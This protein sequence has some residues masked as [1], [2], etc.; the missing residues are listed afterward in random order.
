MNT[1]TTKSIH[2]RLGKWLFNAKE[3]HKA[4][5]SNAM[6]A[7]YQAKGLIDKIHHG[8]YSIQ[9]FEDVIEDSYQDFRYAD[10][11]THGNGVIGLISALNY[12]DLTDEIA[13]YVYVIIKSSTRFRASDKYF[14]VRSED[15]KQFVGVDKN[16]GFKITNL[17]RTIIDCFRYKH[18]VTLDVAE[19]ALKEAVLSKKI[20]MK[21]FMSY[22]KEFRI[23]SL[24]DK[25]MQKIFYNQYIVTAKH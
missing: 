10:A 23:K 17:E 1:L 6:L 19:E 16:E 22:A 25:A 2:Q 4:G 21:R 18:I 8:V 13:H 11:A 14:I 7:Y 24:A 5:I 3:A 20:D 12:Y 9:G 15:E